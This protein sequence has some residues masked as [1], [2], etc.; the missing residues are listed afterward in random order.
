MITS[1][2]WALGIFEGCNLPSRA[3][4]VILMNY[5]NTPRECYNLSSKCV[6]H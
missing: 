2:S 5:F 1:C 3:Y 4:S 6:G